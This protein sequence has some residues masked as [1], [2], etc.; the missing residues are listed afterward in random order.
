[1]LFSMV[2]IGSTGDVR[3]YILL[4]RELQRR[5]HQTRL[6]AFAPFEEAARQVGM[7]F[8]PLPGSLH[9]YMESLMQPGQHGRYLPAA[10]AKGHR[11]LQGC[12]DGFHLDGQPGGGCDPV[13]LQ[14]GR[15]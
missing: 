15:R 1:M 7:D 8:L 5:G 11:G 3:P 12:A 13:H 14:P 6:I 2:A 10:A 9:H 4:G